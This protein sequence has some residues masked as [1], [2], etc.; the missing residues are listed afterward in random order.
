MATQKQIDDVV[1]EIMYR[2]YPP[3]GVWFDTDERNDIEEILWKLVEY[4]T[5]YSKNKFTP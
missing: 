2:I 5:P 3:D 1:E 4:T